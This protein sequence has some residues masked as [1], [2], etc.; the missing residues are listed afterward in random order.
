MS[1][2]SAAQGSKNERLEKHYLPQ[3][4]H[5]LKLPRLQRKIEKTW[6]L[7]VSYTY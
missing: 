1:A 2:V 6:N 4:E 3:N 7:S 5:F